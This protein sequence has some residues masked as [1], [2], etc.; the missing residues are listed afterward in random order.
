MMK[1]ENVLVF[2]LSIFS[3]NFFSQ[4]TLVSGQV[5]DEGGNP[6][7][8]VTVLVEGTNRGTST[9]FEGTYALKIDD[10]SQ[11]IQFSYIGFETQS[12]LV[13]QQNIIDVILLESLE[14]FLDAVFKW[15]IF[16]ETADII[17]D[18]AFLREAWASFISPFTIFS[19]TFFKK[20][21]YLFLIDLLNS[22]LF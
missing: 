9:T 1:K 21:R 2:L 14:I 7:P 17:S 10:S 13:G 8:G 5:V 3:I 22:V 20:V 4:S 16:F 6:L 11:S 12:I 18:S 19:S 15:I